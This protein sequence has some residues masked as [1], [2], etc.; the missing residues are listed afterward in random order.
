MRPV[1]RAPDRPGPPCCHT[2]TLSYGRRR[3]E[4]RHGMRGL[5]GKGVLVTGGASGIGA[6]TATRFLEEGAKVCIL[7]RDPRGNESITKRLP[8]LSGALT[9]DVSRLEEVRD[10][11]AEAV[12]RMGRV[13]ILI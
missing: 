12:R 11:F 13:D 6:A 8:G 2:S 7:D 3:G 10:A 9:A 5:K 4:R 1:K